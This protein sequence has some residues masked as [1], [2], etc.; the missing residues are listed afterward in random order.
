MPNSRTRT[1]NG[2]AVKK[3]PSSWMIT[4][5]PEDQ[6]EQDDRD[7][8]LEETGHAG[9]PKRVVAKASRTTRSRATSSSTSGSPGAA[10]EARRRRPR[11]GAGCPG[12][13]ATAVEEPRDGDLVGGDQGGRCARAQAA[14]LAGDPEGREAR[15]VGR[16]EV[17]PAGGDRGQAARPATGDGRGR[18]TR[19]GWEVSCRGCPAGP[20]ASRPRTGRRS[21]RRSGGG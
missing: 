8:R 15:L 16:P 19:T 6:D 5:T 10:P 1:L 7:D 13:R 18:S 20:S 21:G 12:S 17:E 14:G 3:W 2:R 11:A 4:R 9:A